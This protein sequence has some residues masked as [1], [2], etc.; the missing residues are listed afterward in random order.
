MRISL[1]T[2]AIREIPVLTLA[3]DGAEGCPVLFYVPGYGGKKESGLS[4]GYR[5]AK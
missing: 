5:L 2:E 1:Q 4:L 3:S